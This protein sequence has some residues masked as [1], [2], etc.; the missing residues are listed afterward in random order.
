MFI[1]RNQEENNRYN[2]CLRGAGGRG[3]VEAGR[4]NRNIISDFS[5]SPASPA[6]GSASTFER[7]CPSQPPAF[8]LAA[9]SQTRGRE[10]TPPDQPHTPVLKVILKSLLAWFAPNA[11][12]ITA[13]DP[14]VGQLFL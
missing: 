4:R 13:T 11:V 9:A 1:S 14:R 10:N 5:L 7:Y 2:M 3:W 6:L 8:I 12:N